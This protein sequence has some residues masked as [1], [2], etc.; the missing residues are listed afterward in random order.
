[1]NIKA[2]FFDLGN[3]L[4]AF[5][6][7]KALNKICSKSTLSPKKLREIFEDKANYQDYETG[8]ITTEKFFSNLKTLSK[9][10]GTEEE[11]Q[12]IVSDIFSPIKENIDLVH[13]LSK[14]Y[15]LGIISNTNPAH[16]EFQERISNF[17]SLFDVRIYSHEVNSRKPEHEIYFKATRALN[18]EPSESLFVDDLIENIESAKVL[19]M[20]TIHYMP[21]VELRLEMKNQ[22]IKG[23]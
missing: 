15:P 4:I 5:D 19:G 16:I 14:N 10:E 2:V 13:D 3:V 17:F 8:L 18:V 21:E 9:F 23:I 22:G 6:G 11:L 1:M 20:Q 7:A 12:Y